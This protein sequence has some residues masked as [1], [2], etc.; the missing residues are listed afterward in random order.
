MVIYSRFHRNPFRGFGA[1]GGQNLAFSITLAIGFY[2]SLYYRTSRDRLWGTLSKAVCRRGRKVSCLFLCV[3][4]RLSSLVLAE[5]AYQ[6]P[7]NGH[8]EIS[9]WIESLPTRPQKSVPYCSCALFEPSHAKICQESCLQRYFQKSINN[10]SMYFTHLHRS[11]RGWI[12]TKFG[13]V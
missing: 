9:P 12:C 2:N 8:F 13:K 1:A 3:Q 7:Q 11:P 5:N 6:R 4:V 10:T